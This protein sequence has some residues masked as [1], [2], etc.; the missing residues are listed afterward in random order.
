MIIRKAE[1]E[2]ANKIAKIMVA[3]WQK[4]FKNI[5][6]E[7]IL[8]EMDSMKVS[9]AISSSIDN[10]NVFVAEQNNEV[11][12]FVGVGE[13]RI[14]ECPNWEAE[15]QAIH[16]DYDVK[17]SGIGT[18]LLEK[19]FTELKNRNHRVVGLSV[20]ENNPAN[21]FYKKLGGNLVEK[22]LKLMGGEKLNENLYE[23]QL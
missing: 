18:Q 17:G 8:Q 13:N 19:A 2:D 15:I 4:N 9:K 1:Q 3:S 11:V 5:V 16:V 6:P 23:F 10:E 22:R 7:E 12:G 14:K 21:K 20:F